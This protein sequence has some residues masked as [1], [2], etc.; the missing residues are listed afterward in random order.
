M[1]LKSKGHFH[2]WVFEF[3]IG[4]MI[5]LA[6]DLYGSEELRAAAYV[7]CL[8]KAAQSDEMRADIRML[9][10]AGH[11]C[12]K[13]LEEMEKLYT[14]GS[15]VDKARAHSALLALRRGGDSLLAVT[16]RVRKV[17]MNA[18]NVGYTPDDQTL[19]A[20]INQV[21]NKD[22]LLHAMNAAKS[23]SASPSLSSSS[24]P[25]PTAAVPKPGD[26]LNALYDLGVLLESVTATAPKEQRATHEFSAAAK[27]F[28]G[29]RKGD[30]GQGKGYNKASKGEKKGGDGGEQRARGPKC[31][32][33]KEFGHIRASCPKLAAKG[34]KQQAAAGATTVAEAPL[35]GF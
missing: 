32:Y 4:T 13:L 12:E 20:V 18:A 3:N 8:L 23:A 35:S 5:Y 29:K 33:C 17:L 19:K 22:E 24:A 31:F 7:M 25:A 28:D 9:S 6:A 14:K 34:D 11:K 27:S 15:E 1:P 26:V 30:K 16:T 10:Q 21:A 2:Q